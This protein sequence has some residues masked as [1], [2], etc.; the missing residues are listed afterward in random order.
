M[1]LELKGCK[2]YKICVII[3]SFFVFLILNDSE[4]I[5]L[6]FFGGEYREI[7]GVFVGLMVLINLKVIRFVKVFVSVNVVIYNFIVIYS[8]KEGVI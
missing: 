7:I 1:V 8:D 3:N 6:L 5:D 2:G 4:I